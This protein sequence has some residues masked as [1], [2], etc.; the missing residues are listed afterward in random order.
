MTLSQETS[1]MAPMVTT[2]M[3]ARVKAREIRA[4]GRVRLGLARRPPPVSL[5]VVVA[6][7][8]DPTRAILARVPRRVPPRPASRDE[9]EL[10]SLMREILPEDG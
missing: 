3:M 6:T 10:A 2:T 5:P 1:M 7:S 8:N 4:K 9:R